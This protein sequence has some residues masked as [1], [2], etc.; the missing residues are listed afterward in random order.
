M[1]TVAGFCVHV[2]ARFRDDDS[3]SQTARTCRRG[4]AAAGVRTQMKS[5]ALV[6]SSGAREE[7]A[8]LL[9][10][11]ALGPYFIQIDGFAYSTDPG[12]GFTCDARCEAGEGC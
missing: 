6:M 3:M 4:A 12:D 7:S 8:R 1:A 2:L 9:R 10:G 11:P 5:D